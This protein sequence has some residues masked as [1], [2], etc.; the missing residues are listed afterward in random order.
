MDG[1]GEAEA[2]DGFAAGVENGGTEAGGLEDDLFGFDGVALA[3]N[4]G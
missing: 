4:F 1:A 3:A 2:G